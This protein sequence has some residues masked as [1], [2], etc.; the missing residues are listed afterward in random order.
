MES[1]IQLYKDDE[2][3]V[4]HTWFLHNNDRLKAFRT[5]RK[6]LL[7]V[8]T[9]IEVGIFGNDFKGSSLEMV[10]TAISEQKQVFEGAA[11]AFYWKPKL[12]IP[13]IYENE[14]NK[15]AFG[16]FLKACL[17]TTDSETVLEEI[18]KLDSLKIKG[19]GP[20]VANLLYFLHP[21]LFPPFNTAIVNGFNL[22]FNQKCKLG[23]WE[24]YLGMRE[25]MLERNSFFRNLLSKDL[26][27]LA[28]LLFEIGSN[29]I[30]IE[31]NA[32]DY[33]IKE[34]EKTEKAKKRRLKEVKE[35]EL[36]ENTHSEMQYHLARLGNSLGYKVW[37][38]RNDHKREWEGQKLGEFSIK[39]LTIFQVPPSVADT[40]ALIDVLWLDKEEKIIA[41]FEVEKSTSIYSGI[42][43]LSDLSLSIQG[44]SCQFYLVAPEKREKE[45]KAQLLRPSIRSMDSQPIS[46]LLFQDLRCDCDAMCKFGDDLTVLNKIAKTVIPKASD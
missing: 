35:D 29:R 44:G 22:L 14:Q 18:R 6:G 13:D 1:L 20:A 7:K 3:S 11:H 40:I 41:G 32:L 24:A 4:Y 36:E 2:E 27:A 28:G 39:N 45:I 46:Y 30:I 42:L 5:I 23:S 26:G 25:K 8:I 38:A 10:V 33:L 16:R 15:K 21:T 43:R 31:D 37:I 34:K 19:L 17:E 12:R 9:E